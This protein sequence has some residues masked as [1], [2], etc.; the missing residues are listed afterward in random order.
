MRTHNQQQDST[1]RGVLTDS[2]VTLSWNTYSSRQWYQGNWGSP[3]V[4]GN[5]KCPAPLAVST[6]KTSKQSNKRTR[7][8]GEKWLRQGLAVFEIPSCA[9]LWHS[10]PPSKEPQIQ[11]VSIFCSSAAEPTSDESW[12]QTSEENVQLLQWLAEKFQQFIQVCLLTL[13]PLPLAVRAANVTLLLWVISPLSC[14]TE[15][16]RVR[17]TDIE[18]S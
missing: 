11:M 13:P 15:M 5:N 9:V 17:E 16:K 3:K 6:R 12:P 10:P 2:A 18:Q 8:K 14:L 1:C 4:I 7:S